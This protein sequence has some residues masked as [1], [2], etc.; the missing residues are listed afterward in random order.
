MSDSNADVVLLSKS[1][2]AFNCPHLF[3]QC[4]SRHFI[5]TSLLKVMTEKDWH[6]L[7]CY[8]SHIRLKLAVF[9]LLLING[10]GRE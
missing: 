5:D 3:P 8:I 7:E 6:F 9:Y 2:P 4:V 10:S 1:L